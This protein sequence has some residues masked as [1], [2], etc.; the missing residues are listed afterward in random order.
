MNHGLGIY[1][2]RR[3][4]GPGASGYLLDAMDAS[5]AGPVARIGVSSSSDTSFEKFLGGFLVNYDQQQQRPVVTVTSLP[6][7]SPSI[8]LLAPELFKLRKG[9]L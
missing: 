7:R 5:W 4:V 9:S 8:R 3:L 2:S 1:N 6:H